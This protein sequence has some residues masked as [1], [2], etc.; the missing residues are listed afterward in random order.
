MTEFKGFPAKMTFT[1]VPNL[2][3]S[4]LLPQITDMVE[5]KVLLHIF[6]I[7]YP[8][9]SIQQYPTKTNHNILTKLASY[10]IIR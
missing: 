5:L 8:K 10:I 9:T 3:F 7:I 1:P 4:S 6:E 2:V